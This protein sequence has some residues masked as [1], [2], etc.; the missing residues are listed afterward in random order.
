MRK[1]GRFESALHLL[2]H[3]INPGEPLL[4]GVFSYLLGNRSV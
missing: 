3:S 2:I 1:A 4:Y